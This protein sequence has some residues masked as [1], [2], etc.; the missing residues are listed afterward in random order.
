[1]LEEAPGELAAVSADSA[2]L[3]VGVSGPRLL[4]PGPFSCLNHPITWR[5]CMKRGHWVVVRYS[6]RYEK[7]LPNRPL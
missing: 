4:G 5:D 1:M 2:F 6:S 3:A 7:A